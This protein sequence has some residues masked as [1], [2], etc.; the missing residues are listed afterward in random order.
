MRILILL[1]NFIFFSCSEKQLTLQNWDASFY[2]QELID[3][4]FAIADKNLTE[5]TRFTSYEKLS[6]AEDEF[7]RL[8]DTYSHEKSKLKINELK[9]FKSNYYNYYKGLISRIEKKGYIFTIAG[10]YKKILNLFPE[11]Q[12]AQDYLNQHNTAIKQRLNRNIELGFAFIK[13]DEYTNAKR[14]FNRVLVFNSNSDDAKRGLNEIERRRKLQ[15]Y[16]KAKPKTNKNITIETVSKQL[17]ETIPKM[18]DNEKSNLYNLGIKAFESREYLKAYEFFES[19][20][21]PSYRET[22]LYLSRTEDKL[23][24]SGIEDSE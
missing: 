5:G 4:A 19:I 20:D 7:K 15:R 11:S 16:K 8:V 3:N 12:E 13:K 23:N 2:D 10:Y 14:C 9:E 21:D 1:L 17:L 24:E 22:T 18:T 6:Y